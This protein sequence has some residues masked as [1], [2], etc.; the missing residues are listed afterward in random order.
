MRCN[1]FFSQR[2]TTSAEDNDSIAA[3]LE[4]AAFKFGVNVM[5]ENNNLEEPVVNEPYDEQLVNEEQAVK[6]EQ[7]TDKEQVVNDE[8]VL[9]DGQEDPAVNVI[10]EA[11][12]DCI[13]HKP[14]V[15][16]LL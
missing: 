1:P 5:H 11:N 10:P 6:D 7:V 16:P 14:K 9:D 13:Q 3:N 8:Q 2:L 4:N 12:P 15:S